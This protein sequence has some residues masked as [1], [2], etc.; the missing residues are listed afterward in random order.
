MSRGNG[1]NPDQMTAEARLSELGRIVAAG[2]LRMREKSSPLSADRGDSS[3]AILPTKSV[4]RP[5]RKARNG[6]R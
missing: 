1:I 3:L 6:G 5:G 4:S 2:V